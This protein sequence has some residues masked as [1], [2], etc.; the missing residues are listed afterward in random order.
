[1]YYESISIGGCFILTLAGH[2]IKVS[3][4]FK[5]DF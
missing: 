4:D 2:K 1:M 3:L 5:L